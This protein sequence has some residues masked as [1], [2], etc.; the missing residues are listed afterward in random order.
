MLSLENWIAQCK[1]WAKNNQW[2]VIA[3]SAKKRQKARQQEKWDEYN[4]RIG[5]HYDAEDN[6]SIVI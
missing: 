2:D 4:K 3:L 5:D 6:E 1:E